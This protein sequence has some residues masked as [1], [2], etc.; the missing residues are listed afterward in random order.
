MIILYKDVSGNVINIFIGFLVI[1][2]L[3]LSDFLYLDV[4]GNI[5]IN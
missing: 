5:V 2:K 4:N 3:L 1:N